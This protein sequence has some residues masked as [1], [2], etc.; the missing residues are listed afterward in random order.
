MR[1]L[2]TK[3]EHEHCFDKPARKQLPPNELGISF[4]LVLWHC[5]CGQSRA[6]FMGTKEQVDEYVDKIR[7]S[8]HLKQKTLDMA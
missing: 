4:Q 3:N 5:E 1:M 8:N 6:R 2:K 7:L